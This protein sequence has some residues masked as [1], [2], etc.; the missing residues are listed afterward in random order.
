MSESILSNP[1]TIKADAAIDDYLV[2]ATE[3]A[4]ESW[5]IAPNSYGAGYDAGMRDGLRRALNILRG[6]EE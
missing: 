2:R 4:R 6:V 3:D 5:E 1:D